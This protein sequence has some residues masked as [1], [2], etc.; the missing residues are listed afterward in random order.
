MFKKRDLKIDQKS[1]DIAK[2]PKKTIIELNRLRR[3]IITEKQDS[4][5]L[6][7]PLFGNSYTQPT[8]DE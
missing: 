6:L 5:K 8:I 7:N 3:T 2:H 4:S 1:K